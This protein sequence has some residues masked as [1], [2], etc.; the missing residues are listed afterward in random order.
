[1]DLSLSPIIANMVLKDLEERAI[2]QLLYE[3]FFYFR[4]V[5]GILLA[6][7]KEFLMRFKTHFMNVCSSQLK[8]MMITD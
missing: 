7:P 2:Q 5:D 1:M 3:L 8:L 4:Y 6:A